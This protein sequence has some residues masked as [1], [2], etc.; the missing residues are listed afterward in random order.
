MSLA[1]GPEMDDQP[2]WR[3]LA[4]NKPGQSAR[5]RAD[6]LRKAAPVKSF[7]APLV[8][9]R[10]EEWSWGKGAD[11]EVEVARRLRKL[12]QGWRVIHS[13]PVGELG[14]DIDHVVIGPP[15]VFTLN[16]KNHRGSNMKVTHSM[17]Y[18]NG[19][20]TDYL[21][22][23]RFEAQRATNLLS[24][25][26]EGAIEAQPVIVVTADQLVYDSMP[27]DVHVVGRK[28]IARWLS[29]R[30]VLLTAERVEEIYDLARR[31]VTW[32]PPT[33]VRPATRESRPP[34]S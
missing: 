10:R 31:E 21:R 9:V 17:I 33:S 23:S 25:A 6:A 22:N 16:T 7:L 18:R 14:S 19:V 29:K 4:I 28:S 20:H 26:G 24:A 11:G 27:P 5:E 30:P 3:D 8:G 2:K 12:G 15:G 1:A 32:Q 34:G 13:V